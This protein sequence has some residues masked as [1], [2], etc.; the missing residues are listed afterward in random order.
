M[1]NPPFIDTSIQIAAMREI[2]GAIDHFRRGDF[3]CALTLAAAGQAM[4]PETDESHFRQ[5]AEILEAL[6]ASLKNEPVDIPELIHWLKHGTLRIGGS[7][8][9]NVRIGEFAVIATIWRGIAKFE[10]YYVAR[11][12]DRTPQMLNF[13]RWAAA[14]LEERWSGARVVARLA[15]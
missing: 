7:I 11:E 1:T 6:I 10:S 5:K 12:G 13:E 2:H 8:N 3:E 14:Y 9:E 15:S 4:V